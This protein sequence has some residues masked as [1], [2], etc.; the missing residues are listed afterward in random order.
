MKGVDEPD[1]ITHMRGSAYILNFMTQTHI[2]SM[3]P[4]SYIDQIN[5]INHT[6]RI[7][8]LNSINFDFTPLDYSD[9]ILDQYLRIFTTEHKQE[10]KY[11]INNYFKTKIA[12]NLGLIYNLEHGLTIDDLK[13]GGHNVAVF[14]QGGPN[15]GYDKS[16]IRQLSKKPE[17]R[18]IYMT[19]IPKDFQMENNTFSTIYWSQAQFGFA[20][21]YM[22]GLENINVWEEFYLTPDDTADDAKKQ[23]LIRVWEGY[24]KP[25]DEFLPDGFD[26]THLPEYYKSFN[27]NDINDMLSHASKNATDAEIAQWRNKLSYKYDLHNQE[28]EKSLT[29]TQL[30]RLMMGNIKLKLSETL[31]SSSIAL[32]II[33][34]IRH[35]K[36][37]E[38]LHLNKINLFGMS[39]GMWDIGYSL[40]L[41]DY[42]VNNV[43]HI[44]AGM[45]HFSNIIKTDYDGIAGGINSAGDPTKNFLQNSTWIN[46]SDTGLLLMTMGFYDRKYGLIKSLQKKIDDNPKLLQTLQKKLT[47]YNGT[48]DKTVYQTTNYENYFYQKNGIQH[49]MINEG[50]YDFSKDIIPEIY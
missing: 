24:K 14:S 8:N 34:T 26:Q 17:E 25:L 32:H 12:S 39:Y 13:R 44:Y 43:S 28:A 29:N 21:R 22:F 46:S 3:N 45:N 11:F 5:N 23:S 42:I 19:G 2:S 48:R 10:I 37:I 18:N 6:S 33:D 50:H 47:I 27:D 16:Y 49:I 41:E 40:N 31:E 4:I 30:M 36:L 15:S 9:N 35:K 7:D 20:P 38:L 1:A